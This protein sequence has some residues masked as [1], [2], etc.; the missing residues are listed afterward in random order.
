[1]A[2]A[3]LSQLSWL[4][5][6]SRFPSK[7]SWHTCMFRRFPWEHIRANY[8]GSPGCLGGFSRQVSVDMRS[9]GRQMASAALLSMQ[10]I[11]VRSGSSLNELAGLS[12]RVPRR[13]DRRRI[14][15]Q[16]RKFSVLVRWALSAVF[17]EL[18][19]MQYNNVLYMSEKNCRDVG[20]FVRRRI[21][22][23]SS[24]TRLSRIPTRA[25]WV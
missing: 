22:C 1:M 25:L 18:W 17:W 11:E 19:G 5:K 12:M 13:F 3:A 14:V 7:L 9:H 4:P 15:R 8:L 20:I 23:P 21:V 24:R 6:P 10:V 16:I 2:S